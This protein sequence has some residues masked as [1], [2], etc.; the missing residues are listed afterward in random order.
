MA[1]GTIDLVA[2][3]VDLDL[4][5][6]LDL[7]L[8][9]DLEVNDV[10]GRGR[11][12]GHVLVDWKRPGVPVN[13]DGELWVDN[14]RYTDG[15]LIDH[16]HATY[17]VEVLRGITEVDAQVDG[18]G[19]HPWGADA[20]LLLVPDLHVHV[21]DQIR[22]TGTGATP[23]L[24]YSSFIRVDGLTAPFTFDRA[25]KGGVPHVVAAAATGP[26]L[27]RD[28]PSD[29]G[30]VGVELTGDQLA[31]DVDLRRG[32]EPYLVLPELHVDLSTLSLDAPA[33]LFSPTA[34]QTWTTD[35]P[36]RLRVIDGGLADADIALSSVFGA[37]ALTGDV[38]TTGQL[39]GAITLDKLDLTSLAELAPDLVSDLSGVVDG[40]LVLSGTAAH[41]RLVLRDLHAED[42][43][44]PGLAR[45]M[46]VDGAAET[47]PGSEHDTLRLD[48]HTAVDG[49]GLLTLRGD[50]PVR[51]DLSHPGLTDRGEVDLDLTLLPGPLRRFEL[52][53][54]DTEL[55][56]GRVSGALHM[57]GLM[58]DPD[59][60]LRGVAEVEVKGLQEP[61]RTELDLTRRQGKLT[62]HL[63]VYEGLHTIAR[64]DG[65]A[66]TRMS[67]VMAWLLVDGPEPDFKDPALF[68]DKMDVDLHLLGVDIQ[69][70]L[71]VAELPLDVRGEVT[72]KISVNGSPAA[73]DL[74][75]DLHVDGVASGLPLVAD[76]VVDPGEGPEVEGC[77]GTDAE[78]PYRA[79]LMLDQSRGVA[80]PW[81]DVCGAIPLYTQTTE[82][83]EA[84]TAARAAATMDLEVGGAGVPLRLLS[85][86][87]PG[88]VVDEQPTPLLRRR[89]QP[90]VTDEPTSNDLKISG[91]I[92]GTFAEILPDLKLSARGARFIYRPM[93]IALSN[94]TID[95]ALYPNPA[96]PTPA[97]EGEDPGTSLIAALTKF[98]A[99]TSPAAV[100]FQG[101]PLAVPSRVTGDASV[102]LDEW[103]AGAT[104]GTLTLSQA[105]IL[106]TDDTQ[107]R[108]SGA[109]A[110]SGAWPNLVVRAGEEGVT[111]DQ[112]F[113]S[114]D[115]NNLLESRDLRLDPSIVVH[116]GE[117]YGSDT[118]VEPPS[119]LDA[120]DIQFRL[121]LGL[122][123]SAHIVMPVLDDLGAVGAQVTRADVQSRVG[124]VLDVHLDRG[125]PDIGGSL[126]LRDG[127][128]AL[129]RAR[130][131]L[132]NNSQITFLG[133]DYANP[134]LDIHGVMEV[135]G[136]D[137]EVDVGGTAGSPSVD[138]SSEAFGEDGALFTVF[139]G[140]PPEDFSSQQAR[141]AVEALSDVL[142]NSVLGG[143]NLGS[144]SVEADG[145]VTMG[146]PL[147][148][149]IYVE[150]I[151]KPAPE[152]NEDRVTVVAEWSILPKLLLTA[153]YGNR[154]IWGNLFW[155]VRF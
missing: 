29:H 81:I 39:D 33:A 40:A 35:R 120:L 75:T 56:E 68:A 47:L 144:V 61:A 31:L 100:S 93:G 132:D 44:L 134:R 52:L 95:G 84:S 109:L 136:G 51:A 9:A 36:L 143:L 124:G 135:T 26:F 85:M 141:A 49:E 105:W 3:K 37:L 50:L 43:I 65:G 13:V 99:S 28:L 32:A 16:A 98:E 66:Q 102:V 1:V 7:D 155:E 147:Y 90:V 42:L 113:F 58:R 87:D 140:Q 59:L 41:P 151:F 121:D 34:H 20:D 15:V 79:H 115:A 126:V 96:P 104:T 131:D 63:D 119:A 88:I 101:L 19:V 64:G 18:H 11:Y 6:P 82:Q 76:L 111:V 8:L 10:H 150:S 116:R 128:F 12:T 127:E 110:V 133:A 97:K 38:T 60:D 45:W 55:N 54:P 149:T 62:T 122:N 17:Q 139:T 2:G 70:L 77:P 130:F 152:L 72:G 148:R 91:H 138:F 23:Q 89:R 125:T 22:V 106:G 30:T 73:P 69:T 27:L 67:E 71:A 21:S 78:R 142:L 80:M 146:I 25:R 94:V 129:L 108:A 14:L 123:T 107:L 137:V 4:Y 53:L 117:T 112:G 153:A 48:L 145:T 5:G 114:F 46:D 118:L 86:L 154:H 57:G 83:S 24:R 74:R 103:S 92:G